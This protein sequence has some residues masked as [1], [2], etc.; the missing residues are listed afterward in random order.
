M[1]LKLFECGRTTD[2]AEHNNAINTD[3]KKLRR[4]YLAMHLF[5]SGYGWRYTCKVNMKLLFQI[6]SFSVLLIGSLALGYLGKATEMGLAIVAGAIGLAFTNIDKISRFKGAGFEAEMR[7]QIETII[8]KET[9]PELVESDEGFTSQAYGLV[10]KAN[11]I[12]LALN[13][14]KFTWRYLGGLVKDS[15]ATK[16][17][18][19]ET[20]NWLVENNLAKESKGKKGKIWS[21]T[22]KGREVFA[23]LGN[24]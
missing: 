17:K 14:S 8:D 20:M 16:E 11:D 6:I 9:E 15:G 22:S 21:L 7:E 10:G 23:N 24:K 18:V 2:R 13:D 19:I 4:S 5:A 3:V 12:V 1:L